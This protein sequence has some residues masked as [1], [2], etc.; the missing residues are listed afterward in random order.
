MSMAES[1]AQSAF[2]KFI[3]TPAG[4]I[5][6]IVAG[7]ALIG[8]GYTQRAGLTGIILMVVGLIPLAAGVFNLCFISALLGG[9]ISGARLAKGKPR[10]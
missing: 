7:L 5:T 2:A 8:W 10:T 9:P 4:R 3:N 1:F 6:R